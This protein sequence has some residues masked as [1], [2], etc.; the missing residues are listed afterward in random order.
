MDDT[1]RASASAP[2][3]SRLYCAMPPRPP[4]ASVTR[5]SIV[6]DRFMRRALPVVGSQGPAPFSTARDQR[7]ETRP[8]VAGAQLVGSKA[9]A[10]E[11]IQPP[12]GTPKPVLARV[13]ISSGR[14][15]MGAFAS[16]TLPA[17]GVSTGI[18]GASAA[19]SVKSTSGTR[20]SR[21]CAI[22]AQS[23]SRRS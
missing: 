19:S 1:A 18:A 20:I 13:R 23:A 4:K 2:R 9:P 21:L 10:A 22:P 16:A 3:K 11:F 5:A 17:P 6:G 12:V 15:T 14:G 8:F 7:R